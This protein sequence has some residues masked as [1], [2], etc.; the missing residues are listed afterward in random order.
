MPLQSKD[1]QEIIRR[2]DADLRLQQDPPVQ[3]DEAAQW[4]Q[5]E[6]VLRGAPPIDWIDLGIACFEMELYALALQLFSGAARTLDR[7][8]YPEALVTAQLLSGQ[9]L[10]ALARPLDA[11]ESLQPLL[12]NESVSPDQ[13]LECAYLLGL[14]Y[15]TCADSDS[16]S[17]EALAWAQHFY[18][19]VVS[20]RRSYR[21]AN[22]R[23]QGLLAVQGRAR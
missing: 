23:L 14:A 20:E 16:S 13:R 9:A 10:L 4:L 21:D 7:D 15:E 6:K 11:I 19:Q 8:L 12:K 17:S 5:M 18:E 1:S 2:L 22:E 3:L